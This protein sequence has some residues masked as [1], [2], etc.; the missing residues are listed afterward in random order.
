MF[1][2]HIIDIVSDS[3][4]HQYQSY[5]EIWEMSIDSKEDRN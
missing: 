5:Q 1:E 2:A 3:S 4:S